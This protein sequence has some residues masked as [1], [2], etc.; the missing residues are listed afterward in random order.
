MKRCLMLAISV[1]VLACGDGAESGS[2]A[3][4]CELTD[5]CIDFSMVGGDGQLGGFDVGEPGSPTDLGMSLADMSRDG[6]IASSMDQDVLVMVEDAE[7]DLDAQP[8]QP[9]LGGEVQDGSISGNSDMFSGDLLDGSIPEDNIDA[10]DF[11]DAESVDLCGNGTL[12]PGETEIDCGGTC[13]PCVP[14]EACNLSNPCND[15]ACVLGRCLPTHC[16]DGIQNFNEE[17]VDCGGSCG[18]CS[19][20][21]CVRDRDCARGFC[22]AGVCNEPT[23]GNGMIDGD[24]ECDDGNQYRFDGCLPDCITAGPLLCTSSCSAQGTMMVPSGQFE[25]RLMAS[26]PLPGDSFGLS[27]AKSNDQL[28]IG[29]PFAKQAGKQT[30]TVSV[31]RKIEEGFE[32]VEVLHPREQTGME[33]FGATLAADRDTLVVGAPMAMRGGEVVGAVYVF[34]RREGDSWVQIQRLHAS[35]AEEGQEFGQGGLVVRG[36]VLMVG[37]PNDGLN[38]PESG[39]VY[40]FRRAPDGRFQEVQRIEPIESMPYANFGHAVD[41]LDGHLLVGAPALQSGA[42]GYGRF[43]GAAYVFGFDGVEFSELQRLSA[44]GPASLNGFNFGNVVKL[45]EETAVITAP[46]EDFTAAQSGVIYVYRKDLFGRLT[47]DQKF[48]LPEADPGSLLGMSVSL[49]QEFLLAGQPFRRSDDGLNNAGSVVVFQSQGS[50]RY[51][52]G[53]LWHNAYAARNAFYGGQ[54]IVIDETVAI[55]THGDSEMGAGSGAVTLVNLRAPLC[56]LFGDCLCEEGAD[57]ESCDNLNLCGD[58]IV[59]AAEACDTSIFSQACE[60]GCILPNCSD[61]QQNGN[62]TDVD[63]GGGCGAS[64]DQGEVCVTDLDCSSRSCGL[65]RICEAPSCSD[66]IQNGDECDV[67]CGASC[68]GQPCLLD[69]FCFDNADC[70]SGV[71][72]ADGRCDPM[73]RLDGPLEPDSERFGSAIDVDGARMIVGAPDNQQLAEGVGA[74]YIFALSDNGLWSRE[75]MLLPPEIAA[76]M[77]FGLSVAIRGDLALVGAPGTQLPNSNFNTGA[78]FVFK[79]EFGQWQFLTRLVTNDGPYSN[80]FGA[81]VAISDGYLIVG[82]PGGRG[83]RRGEVADAGSVHIFVLEDDGAREVAKLYDSQGAVSS[84]FGG[85]V[86][87]ENSLLVVGAEASDF[88]VGSVLIYRLGDDEEAQTWSFEHRLVPVGAA[89]TPF[90]GS[91]LSLAGNRLVV[92]APGAE[93]NGGAAGA[94]YIYERHAGGTWLAQGMA[95]SPQPEIQGKFGRSVTQFGDYVMVGQRSAL[96]Q[97]DG[98]LPPGYVFTI[99]VDETGAIET[100]GALDVPPDAPSRDFGAAFAVDSQL[101]MIGAPGGL[102]GSIFLYDEE[103]VRTQ[104]SP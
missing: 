77:R 3:S 68:A 91:A 12:D 32:E 71:C 6:G 76:Q 10:F 41:Y 94:I 40:M 17:S 56:D 7:V 96:P 88:G 66:G 19:A 83:G 90:F 49:H 99:F 74:A 98:S 35:G 64:C 45:T 103:A 73:K 54:T 31:F 70:E 30:G 23:C 8:S 93:Q 84:R 29:A 55:S 15:G 21:G 37:A 20:Q 97:G 39:A 33:M 102:R 46:R 13:A 81:S 16:D 89:R 43:K 59:Q 53:G 42:N 11:P 104:A 87:A 79:H 47:E 69:Q 62:E 36:D 48:G 5:S 28:F 78:V 57:G 86:K 4:S 9:D 63:C 14:F 80:E 27:V 75:S 22:D 24:E 85:K 61:G 44:S 25:G 26:S 92:G 18:Q 34:R 58:G 67:D 1:A 82:A 72:G 65:S 50:D 95:Y 100:R 51:R 2:P 52:F 38:G 60:P 101:L